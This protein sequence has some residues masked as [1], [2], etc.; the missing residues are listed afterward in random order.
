MVTDHGTQQKPSHRNT[1]NFYFWILSFIKYYLSG[2]TLFTAKAIYLFTPKVYAKAKLQI[3]GFW[4][5][6]CY[7]KILSQNWKKQPTTH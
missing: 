1:S 2:K 5:R 7:L 4:K 3:R 6:F